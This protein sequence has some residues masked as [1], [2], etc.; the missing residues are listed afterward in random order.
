MTDL[1]K[2][3]IIDPGDRA[4]RLAKE[5]GFASHNN[6]PAVV[7]V[8]HQPGNFRGPIGYTW[9]QHILEQ[10]MHNNL[11]AWTMLEEIENDGAGGKPQFFTL[12]ST[13]EVFKGL[14]WEIITMTADDFARSGRFPA[15]MVNDLNVKS[16]TAQN[17]PLF[18]SCMEGYGEAIK[19]AALVNLTGEIAVMK[20]SVTAFCDEKSDDQLILIWGATCVGL[21]YH[22]FLIDGSLIGPNMPIVGFWEP[23][24]RCN[25][26]T[27][28]TNLFM[29]KFGPD[30][31]CIRENS[32]A[33]AFV[34][35]L[36]TPSLS[37][38][39]TICR[40]VGWN[41]DGSP[42]TPLAKIVG[43][44]HITGGGVWGK[45]GEILPDGIGAIL[46][47]MPQ[48]TDILA[49]A[50]AL[51]WNFGDLR[52]TDHQAYRT[53]HGGCGMFLVCPTENDVGKVIAEAGNDGIQ[54]QVV[55]RTYDQ[56]DQ[57]GEKLIIHS[58]FREGK[59]LRASQPE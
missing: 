15:V 6:C 44:A 11:P 27:F 5:V 54:A 3:E 38:A 8:P 4:S 46:D 19:Q 23:G 25:G 53:F 59:V 58:R 45:F 21:A 29:R 39:R 57:N 56:A 37:Y 14:G 32:T 1:Y 33:M 30:L 12:V 47:K 20:H 24:Y 42:G 7:V 28:F 16:I 55:G 41:D 18:Q 52:L 31:R 2:K 36:T 34:K 51:S 17:F 26:G 10:M 9:K 13:P 35:K 40:L 49:Q 43:C 48:P 22:D 50:Q